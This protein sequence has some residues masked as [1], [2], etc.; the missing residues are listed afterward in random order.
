MNARPDLER[1]VTDWLNDEAVTAGSDRVLAAALVRVSGV[2]QERTPRLPRSIEMPTYAKLALGVAAVVVV[3]VVG[4]NL[5]PGRGGGIG[6]STPTPSPSPGAS[7]S[8]SPGAS[9]SPSPAAAFPPP[10][11]LTPGRH[12][13]VLDGVPL[14][15]QVRPGWVA[16]EYNDIN[17]GEYGQ[18]DGASFVFWDSAPDNVYGDPCA[19]APLSPPPGD[20]SE[21][22]AAAVSRLPGTDLVDGP[23][24]VTIGGHPG[25]SVAIR[26]AD[27]IDCDVGDFWRWYDDA[28]GGPTGGW[29]NGAGLGATIRVW[30][31][32]VDGKRLWIDGETF[33]GADSAVGEEMQELIDSIQFE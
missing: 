24:A 18:S 22:L 6:G 19:H 12:E 14:S 15:F 7:P 13:A 1:E 21:A 25:Q 3:A 32:D 26:V 20:S 23:T 9:P 8:P 33:A 11:P 5:L 30:I 27:D 17:R 28:T 2:G 10:G 31:I 29:R 4:I 16:D